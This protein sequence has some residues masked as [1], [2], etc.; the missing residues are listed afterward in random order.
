[1]LFLRPVNQPLIE[2]AVEVL[3]EAVAVGV[4]LNASCPRVDVLSFGM[5]SGW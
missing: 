5:I 3:P 4:A 2:V 1:M